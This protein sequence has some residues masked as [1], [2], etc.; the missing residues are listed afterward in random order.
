[1]QYTTHMKWFVLINVSCLHCVLPLVFHFAAERWILPMNRFE[2]IDL[3]RVLIN[4]TCKLVPQFHAISQLC[5]FQQF[6]ILQKKQQ[7]QIAMICKIY[8]KRMVIKIITPTF[9]ICQKCLS[10]SRHKNP[11]H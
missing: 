10:M 1:M 5:R 7:L 3:N 4:I 2:E 9:L 8:R 11:I 6:L